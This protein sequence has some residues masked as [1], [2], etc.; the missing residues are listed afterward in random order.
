MR[1]AA[2]CMLQARAYLAQ[3]GS[4]GFTDFTRVSST[5]YTRQQNWNLSQMRGLKAAPK[6]MEVILTADLE[7]VGKAGE[8]VKVAKGF[9]RNHLIPQLLALPKLEKYVLLVRKQLEAIQLTQ[10]EEEKVEEVQETKTEEQSLKELNALLQ[11]LETQRVVLRRHVPRGSSTL[12]E[13]VNAEDLVAEVRRQQK[14]QLQKINIELMSPLSALG[15]YEV[16]IRLPKTVQIPGGRAKIFLK[17]RI[18]RA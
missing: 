15:E 5:Q 13:H 9:A 14:V 1:L 2:T 12:R 16:P 3:H 7:K 10:P 6:Q 11:R 17:V 18:R 4:S 8:I